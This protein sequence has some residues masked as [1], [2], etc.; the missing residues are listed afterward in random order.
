MSL[1]RI[2]RPILRCAIPIQA[3]RML[4]KDQ[5]HWT[6]GHRKISLLKILKGSG[7]LENHYKI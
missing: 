2:R 6:L 1:E 4:G 7:V 5:L 3:L